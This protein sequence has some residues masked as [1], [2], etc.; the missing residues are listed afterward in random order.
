MRLRKVLITYKKSSYQE[1]ALD[2]HDVDYIRLLQRRNPAIRRSKRA[3]DSHM[4]TL[5]AVTAMLKQLKIPFDLRLR[6]KLRPIQ[7]YDLILT[8]GGDGTF[9]ETSHYVKRGLMLGINSVPDESVGFFCQATARTFQEK[10]ERYLAGRAELRTLHRLALSIDRKRLWALSLNDVLFAN[11]NPAGTTRYLLKI[12]GVQ[13]EQKSSGI[14]ISPAPGSTAATKSAGGR[15]LPLES[16]RVQYVVREP[17]T[18]PGGRYH[19][20]RGILGPRDRI[21]VTSMMDD[22]LVFIDGPHLVFHI[23]RGSLLSAWNSGCPIQAIW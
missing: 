15:I 13:E 23:R 8:I 3:H 1:K 16:D 22:A 4:E 19:L 9:L 5:E 10:I 12:G 11:S 21:D 18:P 14:W 7:G 2:R 6:T 20:L 17:Y